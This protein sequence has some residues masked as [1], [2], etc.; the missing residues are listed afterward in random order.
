MNLLLLQNGYG[1]FSAPAEERD[2]YFN[3]LDDNTFH[4]Y[5][6]DKV[7]AQMKE[8]QKKHQEREGAEYDE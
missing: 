3:S 7:L 6:T 1:Y 2:K 4:I 8:Q 5:A